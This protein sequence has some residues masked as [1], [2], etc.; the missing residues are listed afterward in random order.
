MSEMKSWAEREINLAIQYEEENCEGDDSMYG[1]HCYESALKAFN[2]LLEDGHSGFSVQITRHILDRLCCGKP[3]VPIEDTEDMW[4]LI[5]DRKDGTKTYQCR[6]MASF[7]KDVH[8]DGTVKYRDLDRFCCINVDNPGASYTSGFINRIMSELY[9]ITMPYLPLDESFTVF[10]EDFLVDPKAG[11]YDTKG[12]LYCIT[13]EGEKREINRYFKDGDGSYGMKEIDKF[14]YIYRKNIANGS[15]TVPF[16]TLVGRHV[17]TGVDRGFTEIY[18]EESNWVSF[19][20]DGVTYT[21]IEDPDDGYRSYLM[22]NLAISKKEC[23]NTFPP[24]AVVCRMVEKD[25]YW[26]ECSVLVF[27]DARTHKQVLAI[28]TACTDDYYPYCV[29]E[30][31]PENFYYNEGKE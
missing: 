17:L 7:F 19:T 24:V 6:R 28:G 29:M 11:D 23:I 10:T 1:V 4:E 31:C 21:A 22:D 5:D 12:I 13:P 27:E 15:G 18:G 25:K 16:S 26:E 9:P 2:L 30:Y 3:L 8:P 20:L 14:E